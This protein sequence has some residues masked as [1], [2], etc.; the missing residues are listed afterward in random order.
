MHKI[1][2]H[3]KYSD[4]LRYYSNRPSKE[5]TDFPIGEAANQ[6]RVYE[7]LQE[8]CP[9]GLLSTTQTPEVVETHSPLWNQSIWDAILPEAQQ[10]YIYTLKDCIESLA[11]YDFFLKGVEIYLQSNGTLKMVNFA[12]VHH[13]REDASI[14]DLSKTMPPSILSKF[15]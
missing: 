12:Q 6:C 1:G 11:D 14:L 5:V 15:W 10:M 2:F 13:R 9:T 4:G 3:V 7:L 8:I